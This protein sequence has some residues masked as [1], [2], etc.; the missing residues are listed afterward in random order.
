MTEFVEKYFEILNFNN[1][2]RPVSIE[3]LFALQ[4]KHLERVVF[5]SS[6]CYL[7]KDM[8]I[9]KDYLLRKVILK[10]EGG[11][12]FEINSSFYCLLKDLGYNVV[13]YPCNVYSGLSNK[14]MPDPNHICLIVH[15]TNE[16]YLVDVGYCL[17][18]FYSPIKLAE[19]VTDQGRNGSFKLSKLN[20]SIW[21]LQ[22]K[23]KYRSLFYP[24]QNPG[25]WYHEFQMNMSKEI[26]LQDVDDI[27]QYHLSND[28][29]FFKKRLGFESIRQN[30]V[31]SMWDD[32][33]KSVVFGD[34]MDDDI[35]HCEKILSEEH[36]QQI[37]KKHYHFDYKC[38]V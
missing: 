20:D 5:N 37:L 36:R 1:D 14:L 27:L 12:C 33:F 16:C 7:G 22:S 15:F 38:S 25:E 26:D 31:L 30:C 29:F 19:G 18:G 17:R 32:E 10:K 3:N 35:V 24:A 2:V 13:M 21:V 28:D 8:K 11:F 9:T 23:D 6:A 34:T 4:Q